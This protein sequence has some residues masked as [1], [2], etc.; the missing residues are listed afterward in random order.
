MISSLWVRR[1]NC[2]RDT[3]SKGREKYWGGGE[4]S[5]VK[6]VLFYFIAF[7]LLLIIRRINLV[8]M[9]PTKFFEKLLG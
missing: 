3:F 6:W 4:G 9:F 5:N 8:F 1:G 2:Q 7:L